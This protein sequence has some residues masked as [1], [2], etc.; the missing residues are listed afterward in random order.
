MKK[1]ILL[2]LIIL[3]LAISA[4]LLYFFYDD[5]FSNE[6]D[7][8][9]E[10]TIEDFPRALEYVNGEEEIVLAD[11]KLLNELYQ[12][13][14]EGDRVYQRWIDVGLVKKRLGDLEGTEEAWQNAV[15]YNPDQ[16]LAYGNLAGLYGYR[17]KQ[18]EKAEEYYLK[19]IDMRP[20]HYGYYT[21]LATIYQHE[22]TNK[23][24]QIESLIL[25]GAKE[26]AGK[27]EKAD[28]YMFLSNYFYE[29]GNSAKANEYAQKAV[30]Y[31]PE[32]EEYIFQLN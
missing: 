16:P 21:D 11:I 29:E 23:K 25:Q 2:I 24:D 13:I 32:L 7:Y 3:I 28:F 12:K 26:A 15:S 18:Y 17:L 31:N 27:R 4:A 19:A 6:D 14:E 1:K 20:G 8:K 30:D 10:Y 5:I 9:K 22:L